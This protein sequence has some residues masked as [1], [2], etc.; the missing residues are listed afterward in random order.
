MTLSETPAL[1]CHCLHDRRDAL[2]LSHLRV[3][4]RCRPARPVAYGGQLW[5]GG[6]GQLQRLTLWASA[7]PRSSA[8]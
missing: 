5:A 4:I 2:L 7:D 1:D 6:Q 8:G 3:E